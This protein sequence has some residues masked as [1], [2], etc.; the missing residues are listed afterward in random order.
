MPAGHVQRVEFVARFF[1]H[2]ED[3]ANPE[4][5]RDA[6]PPI[7]PAQRIEGGVERQPADDAECMRIGKRR[8]VAVEIRE[9]V[10]ALGKVGAMNRAHFL[11]ALD[12]LRMRFGRRR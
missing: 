8:P 2:L 10:K 9:H 3:V 4:R 7:E 11:H 1:H 6:G 5:D 12:D